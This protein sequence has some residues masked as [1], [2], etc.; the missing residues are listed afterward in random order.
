MQLLALIFL[1]GCMQ[2]KDK[3]QKQVGIHDSVSLSFVDIPSIDTLESKAESKF[4]TFP[5]PN[6]DTL[7]YYY[8][9][10]GAEGKSSS[11]IY[12]NPSDSGIFVFYSLFE[13]KMIDGKLRIIGHDHYGSLVTHTY[14]REPSGWTASDEYQTF[15]GLVS[16]SPFFSVNDS[17]GVGSSKLDIEHLLGLPIMIE[18]ST[19]IHLGLN[20]VIGQFKYNNDTVTK[21]KYFHYSLNDEIYMLDSSKVQKE[22]RKF[23]EGRII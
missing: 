8:E 2:K 13:K 23:L 5:I 17:I 16:T 19:F 12:Y 9:T 18:D 1:F 11:N 14:F 7:L 21:F 4:K 15:I 3:H 22:V 10:S 20:N 6:L